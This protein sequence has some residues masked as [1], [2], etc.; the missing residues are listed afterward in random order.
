MFCS[1][2]FFV[3]ELMRATRESGRLV[4]LVG[5]GKTSLGRPIARCVGRSFLAILVG[6]LTDTPEIFKILSRDPPISLP[7]S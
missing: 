6:G 3:R 5:P 4:R 2:L 7:H 1:F